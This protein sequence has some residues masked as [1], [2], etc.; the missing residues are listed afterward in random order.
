[1]YVVCGMYACGCLWCVYGVFV[2]GMYVILWAVLA[3]SYHR[4]I[5]ERKLC[6]ES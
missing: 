6:E 1:M 4:S 3:Q 2:C 5:A